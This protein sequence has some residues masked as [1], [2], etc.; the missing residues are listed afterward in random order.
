MEFESKNSRVDLTNP[1]GLV[2]I[3]ETCSLGEEKSMYLTINI[4]SV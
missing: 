3:L 1:I 4:S 2:I